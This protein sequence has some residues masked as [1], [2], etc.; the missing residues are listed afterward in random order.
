MEDSIKEI[1][2]INSYKLKTNERVVS[3]IKKALV[4]YNEVIS[5]NKYCFVNVLKEK[6]IEAIEKEIV[7]ITEKI[8]YC[9]NNS[10][11]ESFKYDA[12]EKYSKILE[13]WISIFEENNEEYSF[14]ASDYEI[15]ALS[16]IIDF[17][18]RFHMGQYE[19]ICYVLT[20]FFFADNIENLKDYLIELRKV[21]LSKFTNKYGDSLNSSYGIF[22][23]ELPEDITFIAYPLW[24]ILSKRDLW[25]ST[26]EYFVFDLKKV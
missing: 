21:I 12:K 4:F 19:E 5:Q 8:F 7:E 3:V 14:T 26:K 13:K 15:F 2:N 11:K 25:S 24:L 1:Y 16:S 22:N 6:P 17:Y 9:V 20:S 10:N 18:M 23:P